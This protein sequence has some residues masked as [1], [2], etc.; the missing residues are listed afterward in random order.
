[1][2]QC[3]SVASIPP[4]SLEGTTKARGGI[5]SARSSMDISD[6]EEPQ[7]RSCSVMTFRTVMKTVVCTDAVAIIE[8][9]YNKI[10]YVWG[11][12]GKVRSG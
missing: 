9:S 2:L 3:M 12:S 7:R 1:M 6:I 10:N 4:E 8:D 5:V 11:G